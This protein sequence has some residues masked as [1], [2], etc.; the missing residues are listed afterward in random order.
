MVLWS[1]RRVCRKDVICAGR[2]WKKVELVCW[3]TSRKRVQFGGLLIF[4]FLC[5]WLSILA[6]NRSM[7]ETAELCWSSGRGSCFSKFICML[8]HRSSA[9]WKLPS[10]Q[11]LRWKM[12]VYL[13]MIKHTQLLQMQKATLDAVARSRKYALIQKCFCFPPLLLILLP[14]ESR[15]VS[16]HFVSFSE[17]GHA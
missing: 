3:K 12:A 4:H 11:F 16:K 15:Y 13:L 8:V 14:F 6:A 2:M 1:C 7:A 5:K 9:A 10:E 17:W